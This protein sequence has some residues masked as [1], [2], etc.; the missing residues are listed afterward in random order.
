MNHGVHSSSPV[1]LPG[2]NTVTFKNTDPEHI[3]AYFKTLVNGS[4]NGCRNAHD[5]SSL[6]IGNTPAHVVIAPA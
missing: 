2:G 1:S 3:N 4:S 5:S 6:T